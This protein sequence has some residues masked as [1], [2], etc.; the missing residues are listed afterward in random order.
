MTINCSL[1]MYVRVVFCIF[2]IQKA[3]KVTN[4]KKRNGWRLFMQ[5]FMHQV[6]KKRKEE[7]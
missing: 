4:S 2:L 3:V 5:T 6:K 7:F 1:H